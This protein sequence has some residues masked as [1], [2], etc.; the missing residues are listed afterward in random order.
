MKSLPNIMHFDAKNNTVKIE[1]TEDFSYE[2]SRGQAWDFKKGW[3]SDGHS[4]GQFF[5]HF[6]A[7]TLAALC[8]DKD[9]ELANS[10]E[11]YNFRREGDKNYK[12]N[13]KDLG[14][15]K[16]TVYRRYS[17]VSG[18]AYMLKMRGKLK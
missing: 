12:F 16:S 8:H 4:V 6:D 14:A 15:P 17:A 2:N 3:M 18:Y 7:W 9:C 1:I 10:W 11:S 13:L 5:K